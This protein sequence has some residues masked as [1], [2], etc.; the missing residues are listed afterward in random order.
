MSGVNISREMI[1]KYEQ[2]RTII[3]FENTILKEVMKS[4]EIRYRLNHYEPLI[5]N[6]R[7]IVITLLLINKKNPITISLN[8]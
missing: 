6:N 2:S 3:N 5:I 7:Y 8:S 1:K 4:F